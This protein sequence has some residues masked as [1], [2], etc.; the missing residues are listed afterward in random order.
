[1]REGAQEKE[2]RPSV[3]TAI[4]LLRPLAL[5]HVR[6]TRPVSVGWTEGLRASGGGREVRGGG[7]CG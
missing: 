3:L 2:R 5:L 1:M 6:L 4:L 7:E